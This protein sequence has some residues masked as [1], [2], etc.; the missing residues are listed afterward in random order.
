[1]PLAETHELGT[2]HPL[3]IAVHSF[4]LAPPPFF[5]TVAAC[6][7]GVKNLGIA[8]IE[9]RGGA[10]HRVDLELHDIVR[11][12]KPVTKLTIAELTESLVRHMVAHPSIMGRA[13]EL[14]V[15]IQPS[16]RGPCA[17]T[18]MKCLSHVLQAMAV[19]AGVPVTFVSPKRKAGGKKKTYAQRKKASVVDTLAT[20]EAMGQSA[21]VG[22]IRMLKKADDVCDAFQLAAAH[23]RGE[24]V[25][26]GPAEAADDVVGGE[27]GAAAVR[28]ARARGE[29]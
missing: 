4:F 16:N 7:V 19:A 15:E 5:S 27:G 8:F 1:M 28:G 3:H 24:G 22:Y 25:E 29:A 14:V 17:N 26:V 18:K 12:S 21:A 11:S 10:V 20:L 13:D 23:L 2:D 6:D 9:V